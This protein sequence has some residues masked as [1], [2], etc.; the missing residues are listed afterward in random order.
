MFHG[1]CWSNYV[2]NNVGGLAG[3]ADPDCP[4][5]RGMGQ[6]ISIWNFVDVRLITQWNGEGEQQ[7]D[8]HLDQSSEA[9]PQLIETPNAV[10]IETP[11]SIHTY[12]HFQS[13]DSPRSQAPSDYVAI[14]TT[15]KDA[16]EWS[17]TPTGDWLAC[18]VPSASASCVGGS[19]TGML[20]GGTYHA[21]TRLSDGRTALLIDPGAVGNLSGSIWVQKQASLAL[22]HGRHPKQTKRGRPLDV[23]GAGQGKST[24]NYSCTLPIALRRTD[25]TFS[26]GTFETPTVTNSELPALLGLK[27]LRQR[28]CIIDLTTL[29]LHLCGPGDY[30]IESILP[31]GS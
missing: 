22:E 23:R 8:N 24:C 5:C 12:Y 7:V 30:T 3:V 18:L 29:R 21:D 25:G 10:P 11:R 31:P 27:S 14:P 9:L 6:T 26:G 1:A 16:A 2:S 15:D 17:N 4:N 19:G 28:R 20:V 13:P